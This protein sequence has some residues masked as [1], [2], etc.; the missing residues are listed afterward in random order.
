MSGKKPFNPILPD[1]FISSSPMSDDSISDPFDTVM[2]ERETTTALVNHGVDEGTF[3]LRRELLLHLAGLGLH[4]MCAVGI[5]SKG[6]PVDIVVPGELVEQWQWNVFIG[7]S[8]N[9][10]FPLP[11]LLLPEAGNIV[12]PHILFS[13]TTGSLLEPRE[14]FS[15]HCK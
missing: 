15:Q 3:L 4:D 2:C 14:S 10:L 8:G 9:L 12:E 6:G 7:V 5:L 11:N 13:L 1:P